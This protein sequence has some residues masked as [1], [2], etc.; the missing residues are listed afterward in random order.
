MMEIANGN[1][2]SV[3][4]ESL[5]DCMFEK[6]GLERRPSL[7]FED[8]ASVLNDQLDM[9]WDVCLDWKGGLLFLHNFSYD[10]Q[11]TPFAPS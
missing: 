10:S 7:K 11:T 9:L 2:D 3:E 8:F 4:I 5:V 6:A 1:L